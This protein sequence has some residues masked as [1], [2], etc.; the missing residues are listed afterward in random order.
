[1]SI[2]SDIRTY[3]DNAVSEGKRA[4]G[5]TQAQLN[6]V[7]DSVQA[8]ANDYLGRYTTTAR[9]NV[10]DIADKANEA[11]SEIRASAEKAIN[12]EAIKS[13]IEPYL[14]QVKDYQAAVTDKAESVFT[15]VTNDK[16]VAKVVEQ[17]Q[18]LVVKPVQSRLGWKPAATSP[19][20]SATKPSPT[21]ATKPAA[22]K[23]AATKPAATAKP[24]AKPA[25]TKP[26][27]RKTST[28]RATK[29]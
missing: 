26:A 20:A 22:T 11:V 29:A 24:A 6:D 17:V 8:S 4:L 5:K 13:A 19:P 3:A 10:A 16:R 2:T 25:A 28:K 1:M 7:T 14:A 27:A 15:T 18:D 12:L 23:P 9:E 21:K